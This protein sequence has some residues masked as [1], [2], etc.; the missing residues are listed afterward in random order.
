MAFASN[1]YKI[2][3]LWWLVTSV[4]GLGLSARGKSRSSRSRLLMTDGG[5]NMY[6]HLLAQV[7]G[8]R[9]P[10]NYISLRCTGGGMQAL[11][12]IFTTPGASAVMM[13]GRIPYSFP[14]VYEE[15]DVDRKTIG[16]SL[17]SRETAIMLA[18]NARRKAIELLLAE[19]R[20]LN[21]IRNAN[22]LGISCTAA[23][24]TK[25][26]KKGRHR[27]FVATASGD[28]VAVYSLYLTNGLRSR[29]QEDG[30]CSK[31]IM[32]AIR[33]A[34]VVDGG[35]DEP[36]TEEMVE[37]EVQADDALEKEVLSLADAEAATTYGGKS[38]I[39]THIFSKIYN[40][41]TGQALFFLRDTERGDSDGRELQLG[42][43]EFFENVEAPEGSLVY[44]GSF[45]PLH[46]GH[47]ALIGAILSKRGY[48]PQDGTSGPLVN[49]KGQLHPPVVFEI[50]AVNADK[51]PLEQS[52]IMQR[53]HA[54][55]SSDLLQE[56]GI[57]NVCV[58]VTSEPLFLEKSALFRN[59]EFVVGADTMVRLLNPKYYGDQDRLKSAGG[60]LSFDRI[61]GMQ[62]QSMVAALATIRER[63]CHF[64]VGGR[65]TS[66]SP[67]FVSCDDILLSDNCK[68]LPSEVRSMF[69][70]IDEDEFRVDLSSSEIRSSTAK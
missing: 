33:E 67:S 6:T 11:Q 1:I 60:D 70:G 20:N 50:A 12:W 52:E 55:L 24:A 48:K 61:L 44:P 62:E 16:G 2:V 7:Y 40:K 66:G 31:L 23:L 30:I 8:C 27:C 58:S 49:E 28:A 69:E 43:F 32:K 15:L 47:V 57:A 59:C 63:G 64:I 38:E 37:S 9:S 26:A 29:V 34:C 14:S 10:R 17:C 39:E 42:D 35:L 45:N 25:Q 3:V 22:T 18:R 21:V 5:G 56:A 41:A 13:D 53:T 46:R 54:L 65:A 51:P 4:T 68:Y 19:N 36:S